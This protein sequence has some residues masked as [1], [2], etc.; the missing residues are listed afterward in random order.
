MPYEV[1]RL[2]DLSARARALFSQ[3]IPGAVV[4]IW[5]NTF[6]V[7]AKVLAAIGFEIHL[8]IAW[9]VRQMFASTADDE[10]LE[11]HGFELSVTRVAAQRAVGYLILS[12]TAGDVIP[13]GVTYQR[14]DG[15]I[16]R[17]R[18]SAIGDAGVEVQF[19]AVTPG[20]AGN[21]A[22]ATVLTLVDNGGVLS[23]SDTATV[24][25]GGLG[26][27][28]E[29]E[30]KETYRERVLA[31]KR[32]P[33]QGGSRTDWEAWTKESDGQ[34]TRVF[35]DSFV[36]DTRQVWIAFLRADRV[37][38][39]PTGGDVAVTQAYVSDTI[40][41]PVTARVTVVAPIAVPIDIVIAGLTVDTPATRGAVAAELAAVFATKSVPA[42]P[43]NPSVFYR[44]WIDE[45]IS[46]ATGEASH[47]LT[48]P[49]GNT[50]LT[51]SPEIAV[52]GSITYT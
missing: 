13:A 37:N 41:R 20:D 17:S 22:A 40:R 39:I 42:T 51:T 5:P 30:A 4:A 19:E 26:G 11:R 49:S 16:F 8:R 35:V 29:R 6:T 48:T 15:A 50:T 45:A 46:R 36:N 43:S 9:L 3:S 33:P 27:G 10:W 34:I 28:A 31:R 47:S 32:N 44:A 21:T 1:P 24:A 7:V 18:S 52:L 23:L 14:A 38:G 12:A 25:S 2:A